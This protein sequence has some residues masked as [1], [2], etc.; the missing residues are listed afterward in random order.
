MFMKMRN[1][2]TVVKPLNILQL[3]NISNKKVNP[4]QTVFITIIIL[5]FFL[6]SPLM[7]IEIQPPIPSTFK[8]PFD[9]KRGVHSYHELVEQTRDAVVRVN[10]FQTVKLKNKTTKLMPV[11]NGSGA[12]ID[13]KKGYIITNHHVVEKAERLTIL[14]ADGREAEAKLLGADIVTDIAVIQVSTRL[15]KHLAFAD[16]RTSKVGDIVFT[17]GSPKGYDF[18]FSQGIISAL[19]RGLSTGVGYM[20]SHIQTDAAVNSGNSGGPLLDTQGRIVGINT[21]KRTDAD[22]IGFAVPAR[23]AIHVARCLIENGTF[24]HGIIGVIDGNTITETL[25]QER[26]LPIK[27]GFE[28]KK[29]LAGFPAFNAGLR[30]GDIIT[31]AGEE[32]IDSYQDFRFFLSMVE[33]QN[34]YPIY[35]MRDGLMHSTEISVEKRYN[36]KKFLVPEKKIK[37]AVEA[38]ELYHVAFNAIFTTQ[39]KRIEQ[40]NSCQGVSLAWLVEKGQARALGM[41]VGDI[42]ERVGSVQVEDLSKVSAIKKVHPPTEIIFCRDG[43]R[44]KRNL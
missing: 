26:K 7:A 3:F 8:A 25:A 32:R 44:F 40:K 14:L 36:Q 27:S 23:T 39:P 17:A 4:R 10:N 33:T 22:A 34:R 38:A 21:I 41:K 20:R 13:K 12:V 37:A 29:L 24:E 35:F 1:I 31:G 15:P 18:S 43:Q 2:F 19:E 11:S 42:L 6:Y 5:G 30:S 28:L 16:S 9:E